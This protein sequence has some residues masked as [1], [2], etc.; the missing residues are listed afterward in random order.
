MDRFEELELLIRKAANNF[1]NCPVCGAPVSPDPAGADSDG[2]IHYAHDCECLMEAAFART[3]FKNDNFYND[4]PVHFISDQGEKNDKYVTPWFLFGLKKAY[5]KHCYYCKEPTVN[6]KW[7]ECDEDPPYKF[8]CKICQ[9]SLRHHR[10]YGEGK[11][12]DMAKFGDTWDFD[13]HRSPTP[14]P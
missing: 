14:I 13:E 5:E 1:M 7:K 4:F 8:R 11:I 12:Y 3:L 10:L 2:T 9:R 6:S